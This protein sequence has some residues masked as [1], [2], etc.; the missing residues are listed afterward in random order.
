MSQPLV[1]AR[2]HFAIPTA[3][4]FFVFVRRP[5]FRAFSFISLTIASGDT[6]GNAPTLARHTVNVGE[7]LASGAQQ[8]VLSRFRRPRWLGTPA[9]ARPATD[10]NNA[11]FSKYRDCCECGCF[12]PRAGWFDLFP[13]SS[14]F[15]AGSRLFVFVGPFRARPF[16]SSGMCPP[17]WLESSSTRQR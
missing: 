6:S 3:H 11:R 1:E 12:C 2:N 17:V 4:R 10:P 8:R 16:Q 7:L 15:A 13:V 5:P 14:F 9:L